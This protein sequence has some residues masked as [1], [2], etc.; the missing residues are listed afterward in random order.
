MVPQ[1]AQ[2]GAS[3]LESSR[4]M[5]TSSNMPT[6]DTQ[7][8]HIHHLVHSDAA[9]AA[10]ENM[11]LDAHLKVVRKSRNSKDRKQQAI[12]C[13]CC[14]IEV[15]SRQL[16]MEHTAGVWRE[17]CDQ[18]MAACNGKPPWVTAALIRTVHE[19]ECHD[20]VSLAIVRDK[21][22]DKL[23]REWTKQAL[24]T[25]EDATEAYMVAVIAKSDV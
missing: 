17:L 21:V 7:L 14:R 5:G 22:S 15:D 2:Q 16:T 20:V 25:L 1:T 6:A 11:T 8:Q 18:F 10:T 19:I 13:D 24:T 4:T 23:P 3:G 12:G 9:N